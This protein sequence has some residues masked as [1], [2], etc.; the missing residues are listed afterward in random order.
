[1]L[2]LRHSRFSLDGTPMLILEYR[3][4]AGA[5][6]SKRHVTVAIATAALVRSTIINDSLVAV[7][8][9]VVNINKSSRRTHAQKQLQKH[10]VCE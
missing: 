2:F 8:I 1:M 7:A 5:A 4:P 6:F 9:T 10:W 3:R